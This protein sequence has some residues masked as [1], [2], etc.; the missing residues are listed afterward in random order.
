MK[1]NLALIRNQNALTIALA[2]NALTIALAKNT[3]FKRLV[4][5]IGFSEWRSTSLKKKEAGMDQ[6]II[7]Q[8]G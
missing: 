5:M 2:K 4:S 1:H 8:V 7:K 6:I 3:K